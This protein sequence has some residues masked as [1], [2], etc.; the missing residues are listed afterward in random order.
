MLTH[1]FVLPQIS[2]MSTSCMPV[3]SDA[4]SHCLLLAVLQV[5]KGCPE[6]PVVQCCLKCQACL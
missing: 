1:P 5:P 4:Y 2:G 6:V 3:C